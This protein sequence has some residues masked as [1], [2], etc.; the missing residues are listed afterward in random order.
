MKEMIAGGSR[1]R[2]CVAI[3]RKLLLFQWK[4]S[5]AW[6]AW[7][8]TNDTDTVDGFTFIWVNTSQTLFRGPFM[9]LI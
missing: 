9:I 7:C 3:N 2:M 1:L 4:H 5:A 8:P 6:T